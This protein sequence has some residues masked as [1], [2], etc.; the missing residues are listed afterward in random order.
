MATPMF[1]MICANNVNRSTEAH[2][3]LHNAGLRVCSFG[4]GNMVRF[5]GPNLYEPRIFPFF[6]PYEVMYRELKSENEPLFRRNGV[7]AMLERDIITK[8]APQKW[9]DNTVDDLAKLDVIL[10]FEDRIFDIV[11]E[12]LQLRKPKDFRPLHLICLNIKDTP[13]D[14]K[15]GGS[16]ALD[17]CKMINHLPDLEDGIPQAIEAFE[18][19][20]QLK[21]LYAPLYI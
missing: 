14:A 4:A 17:L 11:M 10:C 9:Q 8:K 7:L 5:P 15:I 3:H 6:T 1:A 20:K 19:Q 21:L 2:D 16:L 12:D 13:E 18:T